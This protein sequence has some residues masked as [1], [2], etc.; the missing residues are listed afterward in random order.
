[1]LELQPGARLLLTELIDLQPADVG[2]NHHQS[3]ED[4]MAQILAE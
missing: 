1:V 3:L 4:L 2:L